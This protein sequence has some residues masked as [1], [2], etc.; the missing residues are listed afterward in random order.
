MFDE[1]KIN[2]LLKGGTE[3]P[4]EKK[5]QP[6]MVPS[7]SIT[8]PEQKENPVITVEGLSWGTDSQAENKKSKPIKVQQKKASMKEAQK[9]SEFNFIKRQAEDR[10]RRIGDLQEQLHVLSQSR[11]EER[12]L[13]EQE[14]LNTRSQE[15]KN[16]TREA[17]Q[18]EIALLQVQNEVLQK[19]LKQRA[20]QERIDTNQQ[21]EID[22]LRMALEEKK[23]KKNDMPHSLSSLFD[24]RGLQGKEHIQ[25]LHWLVDSGI[26][27]IS[28]LY[29][30]NHSLLGSV[31]K[32]KCYIQ[33]KDIPLP[34]ENGSLYVDVPLDRCALSGGYNIVDLARLFKDELLI[35]GCTDVIIFGGQGRHENL[36]QVLFVHHALKINLAPKLS[37]IS[38]QR[39]SELLTENQLA[40]SLDEESYS[41]EGV[42]TPKTASLGSF[43]HLAVEYLRTTL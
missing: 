9:L 40:L 6:S 11:R 20:E 31:L 38:E 21:N 25:A 27:P 28:H 42:F 1:D 3:R 32:D 22:G 26:L 29:I 37:M 36:L 33:A 30:H 34:R 7:A 8:K 17:E 10:L 24:E 13:Y 2:A 4:K 12:L 19:Q 14:R 16:N 43:L 39:R 41:I 18:K 15:E 35:N 5:K 23:A